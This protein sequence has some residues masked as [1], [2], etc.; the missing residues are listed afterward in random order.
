MTI[1]V[2]DTIEEDL[3][4]IMRIRSDPLVQPHQFRLTANAIDDLR[5]ALFGKPSDQRQKA[6]HGME[7]NCTTILKDGDVIGHISQLHYELNQQKICY[8]GWNLT[9]EHWGQGI[10]VLALSDLFTSLFSKKQFDMIVSDCFSSNKRCLRVLEKL[11]YRPSRIGIF[12]RANTAI[13]H[14]SLQWVL[15]F[16]LRSE[17]WK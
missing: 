6:N 15:R 11:N 1:S 8:C 17:D 13:R 2:R 9:P 5:E 16:Y 3:S 12:E 10:I 14:R 4:E 7:F